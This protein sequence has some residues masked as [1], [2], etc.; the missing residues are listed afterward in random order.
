MIGPCIR[1][2]GPGLLQ[3]RDKEGNFMR[4][5]NVGDTIE[6]DDIPADRLAFFEAENM[7]V[8]GEYQKDKATLAVEWVGPR[9]TE[10]RASDE[11]FALASQ[12]AR[13]AVADQVTIRDYT[14][15]NSGERIRL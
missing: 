3:L 10:R 1:W 2:A 8:R 5:V 11:E 12:I 13:E 15:P 4:F 9:I 6:P 14:G 7:V